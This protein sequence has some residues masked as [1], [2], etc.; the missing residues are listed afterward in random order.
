MKI[1]HVSSTVY[2]LTAIT[3]EVSGSPDSYGGRHRRDAGIMPSDVS[4]IQ[5]K[6]DVS[7]TP[8]QEGYIGVLMWLH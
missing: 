2:T 7:E 1:F 5:S 8:S 6:K 3:M 4:I